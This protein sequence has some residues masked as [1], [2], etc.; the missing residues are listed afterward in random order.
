MKTQ[1]QLQ[2]L[3]AERK[4][5]Q[6]SQRAVIWNILRKTS[7]HPSVEELR[8]RLRD[9]GYSVGL[10]TIYRTLNLLLESGM[11]RQ[12]RLAGTTRYEPIVDEPNHLHFICNACGTNTEVASH[13]IERLI[14]EITTRY[15]FQEK[16]SRYSIFGLCQKC[17]ERERRESGITEKE[18]RQKA[19]VRDA[20]E[21]TLAVEKRGYAF[22]NQASR[23]T[24]NQ[25]GRVMFRRLAEEESEHLKKIQAEYQSLMARNRWLKREPVR[26]ASSREIAEKAFPKRTLSKIQITDRT[27]D[28]QAL[29][30][31]IDLERR[32]QEFF[33]EFAGRLP[34]SRGRQ[35]FRHFAKEEE[36]HLKTLI[37]EYE[38]L[39]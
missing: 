9:Q 30:I 39:G 13:R 22:Y 4:L 2:E 17:S 18:R 15:R 21:L 14:G 37:A 29:D 31:A 12:S 3:L 35:F 5:K 26:M 11:I 27:T 33:S 10:A 23:R 6:T 16:F 19:L 38:S 28:R 34:D 25:G 20:L 8:D 24:R 32:S 7:G 1:R 36:S